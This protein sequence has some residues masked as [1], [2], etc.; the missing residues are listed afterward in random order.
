MQDFAKAFYLSKAWRDTREYI[1]KR[2]MGL[3]VRC[4]KV[5]AIVHHKIY[6]TPQNIN[7]PAI[8]LSEDNLE[9]LCRECHTI[10]HEGQLPTASGLMFDSEGNLVEKEGKYGS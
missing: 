7:N 2:D 6:L 4:G 9:L 3:C 10:E 1:Y 5:G 8:T